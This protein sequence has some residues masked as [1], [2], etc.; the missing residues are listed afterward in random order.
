MLSHAQTEYHKLALI[1]S[2]SFIHVFKNPVR[3][4]RNQV[5]ILRK[6]QVLENRNIFP[7][8][9]TILLHRQQNIPLIYDGP[10]IWSK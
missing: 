7:I 6:Q 5:E 9:K 8:I 4:I 1:K 3:D 10:F 2:Q